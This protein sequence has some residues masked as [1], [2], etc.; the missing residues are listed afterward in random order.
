MTRGDL[1]KAMRAAPTFRD[2]LTACVVISTVWH[3][4]V[5]DPWWQLP[6]RVAFSC[7]FGALICWGWRRL[8]IR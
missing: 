6:I 1:E 2:T 8:V 4:I 7:A 5:G 3:A